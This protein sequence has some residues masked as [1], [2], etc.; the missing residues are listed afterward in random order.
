MAYKCIFDGQPAAG[1]FGQDAKPVCAKHLALLEKVKVSEKANPSKRAKDFKLS[2]E[3][4]AEAMDKA[5]PDYKSTHDISDEQA[6]K[7]PRQPTAAE[8]GTMDPKA[9]RL[10]RDARANA[11]LPYEAPR[12]SA[13]GE[14]GTSAAEEAAKLRTGLS[15]KEQFDL[16]PRQRLMKFG[17]GTGEATVTPPPT[18]PS[19]TAAR[20]RVLSASEE[21]LLELY[22]R[23][24]KLPDEVVQAI[25]ASGRLA[26]K[27][28]R[29]A[30]KVLPAL[31]I[32][33]WPDM[34]RQAQEATDEMEFQRLRKRGLAT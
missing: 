16:E 7:Y 4:M 8:R 9:E 17:P 21:K 32:F 31:E 15:P 24:V 18:A 13:Q 34:M 14:Y 28:A 11:D 1:F 23:G 30:G 3:D 26:G 19:V 22:R 2:K 12:Q 5:A 33:A 27:V 10:S 6:R 25:R 20:A 29:G